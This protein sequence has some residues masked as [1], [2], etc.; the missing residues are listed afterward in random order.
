MSPPSDRGL[1]IV[2]VQNDFCE[3][4]S[5]AVAGGSAAAGAIARYLRASAPR[6]ETVVGSQDWH[7]DPGA[8]FAEDPDYRDSW[9]VHCVA[10]TPGAA[11]HPALDAG[12]FAALFRKGAY[13]AAYSAFEGRDEGGRTLEDVLYGHGV[14]RLDVAGI[15]TDYCVRCTGLDALEA[16]FQVRVLANLCAAVSA[17]GGEAALTELASAGAEIVRT[18]AGIPEP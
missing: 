14:E 12:V 18:M 1:L 3:G 5:L 13:G 11:L 15:A 6:Y 10:D 17:E 8:H 4:G 7:V 9:P 2:D 16:G